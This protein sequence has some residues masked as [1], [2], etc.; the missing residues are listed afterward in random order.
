MKAAGI[1]LGAI[2]AHTTVLAVA[3]SRCD[4]IEKYNLETLIAGYGKGFRIP[5]FLRQLSKDCPKRK[6]I[7][8]CSYDLCG[9]HC[10]EL[11]GFFLPEA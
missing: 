1:S 7:T 6:S 4:R 11:P 9:V 8:A 10:P 3:C 5:E 2:A